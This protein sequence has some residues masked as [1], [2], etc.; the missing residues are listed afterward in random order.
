M[1]PVGRYDKRPD[2]FLY[3][4]GGQTG[5]VELLRK[6]RSLFSSPGAQ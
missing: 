2:T 4:P 5:T 6:K 3:F 1:N